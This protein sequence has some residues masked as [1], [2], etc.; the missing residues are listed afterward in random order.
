MKKSFYQLLLRTINKG[1]E[2]KQL[3]KAVL[4]EWAT[5]AS[6]EDILQGKLLSQCAL[7]K[8]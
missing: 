2:S 3:Y 5:T 4:A 7:S 6:L 8:A 1:F